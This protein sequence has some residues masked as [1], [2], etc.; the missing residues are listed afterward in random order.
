MAN[1]LGL[2][3]QIQKKISWLKRFDSG[4]KISSGHILQ[5]SQGKSTMAGDLRLFQQILTT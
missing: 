4:T 5:I 1:W 3:E 2:P